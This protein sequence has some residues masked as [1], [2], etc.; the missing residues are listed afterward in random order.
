MGAADIVRDTLRSEVVRSQ[1]GQN[2]IRVF[3]SAFE[4]KDTDEEGNIVGWIWNAG[5]RLVGLIGDVFKLVGV[6]FT[7]L[8]SLFVSTVQYIWNFNWN[9]TDT[10]IEQQ[11]QARW[12]A[13][14][15]ML[16]GTLGNAFGYLACGVLPGAAIVAFNEPMGA[17]VLKNVAEEMTEEFIANLSNVIRYSFI[18]GVQ[19][20]LLWSFR[21]VR[22]LIKANINFVKAIFGN[23]TE[24]IIRAWGEPGSKPWSFAKAMDDAV[25]SIPNTAVR[26]FVEEF[27]E[28]AWEGC[29]EAG[30]V[31]ANSLDSYIAQQKLAEQQGIPLG[32][33]RYVEIQPDRTNENERIILAGAER[34][35]RNTITQTLSHY[36]LIENRDVGTLVGMPADDYLRAKPQSIRLVVTFISNQQPPWQARNGQRL[37]VATYGIPDVKRSKCDWE[38][39]KLACGGKNGYLWGRFRATASLSN[40]RQMQV[41]GATG[42]EA[43]DR[44]RAL[45]ELS[46]ATLVKKPTISEDRGEDISGKYLK[47]PTRVYPAYFTIMNQYKVPGGRGSGIPLSS[48]LY[49]RKKDKILLWPDEKPFGTDELIQDLLT[50]PGAEQD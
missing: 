34:P 40:G 19:S 47:I 43:E 28:E 35:L 37:V 25:E 17:Y 3:K 5:S 1:I 41:M 50:K 29:V 7:T 22:K 18:S 8:W 12:N 20:L 15:G 21:N 38:T 32:R 4:T 30:Y 13:L 45:L 31:V 39:I 11:I 33:Q 36:Q 23:D 2:G 27:L 10:E 48:G 26:N 46:E 14:S 44:L 16:G 49:N 6:S 9:I 42:D 24:R